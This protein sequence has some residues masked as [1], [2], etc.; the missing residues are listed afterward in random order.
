VET[1]D[2]PQLKRRVRSKWIDEICVAWA[3]LGQ[4]EGE[5]EGG[6]L[7]VPSR[8]SC[9][10]LSI[11]SKPRVKKTQPNPTTIQYHTPS[12]EKLSLFTSAIAIAIATTTANHARHFHLQP[13]RRPSR[14]RSVRCRRS[15]PFQQRQARCFIARGSVSHI[16]FLFFSCFDLSRK[17]VPFSSFFFC[18]L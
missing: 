9:R 5:G 15:Q 16:C 6:V 3:G 1:G 14:A 4:G 10:V 11:H 2:G 7:K 17:P 18:P 12:T 13:T 8:R